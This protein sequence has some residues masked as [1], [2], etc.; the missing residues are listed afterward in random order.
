MFH[1]ENPY[2]FFALIFVVAL[3]AMYIV[4]RKISLHYR[5]QLAKY[6]QFLKLTPAYSPKRSDIKFGVFAVACILIIVAIANPRFGWKNEKI[7]RQSVDVY[8]AID[9]SRSMWAQ[10]IAPNRMER[11]RQTA[12]S[13][14]NDLKGERVGII[15]FAGDAFIQIPLTTDYAASEIQIRNASP[16]IEPV[17]GTAIEE[18]IDLVMRSQ[19]QEKKPQPKALIILTDGENH[20]QDAVT[21]AKQAVAQGISTMIVSFG[22]EQ[23]APIPM[24]ADYET[25]YVTDKNGQ[26]VQSK[27]NAALMQEIA[28]AGN[29]AWLDFNNEG[30]QGVINAIHKQF[31]TMEKAEYEQ[32]SYD[33]AETYYHIPLLLAFILLLLE[34]C[35]PY[36]K[37]AL[38]TNIQTKTNH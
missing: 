15:T 18:A 10:D 38:D 31:A 2:A 35:L 8:L 25:T 7:K 32:Q 1:F 3:I 26:V 37:R 29:G 22:K 14:L 5:E 4:S 28:S 17:Q 6:K 33:D 27:L 36:T 19:A 24:G 20:E 23:G 21:K 34:W 9:V 30:L 11:A 12:L 13:I 16:L